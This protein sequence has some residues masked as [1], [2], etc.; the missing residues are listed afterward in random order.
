[1][2]DTQ[3]K[4][5]RDA[6]LYREYVKGLEEGRFASMCEA[7]DYVIRQPAPRFFISAKEASNRIGRILSGKEHIDRR[8]PSQRRVL[9]LLDR[10]Q[11]YLAAY[12]DCQ[13]SRESILEVLVQEPAPEFYLGWEAARQI[14]RRE[15]S[16]RRKLWA[17]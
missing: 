12:P 6:A 8:S 13:L 4:K 14:L 2:K 5:K 1:M 3:L 16:K 17:G 7:A 9:L 11:D 15:V 10:Y